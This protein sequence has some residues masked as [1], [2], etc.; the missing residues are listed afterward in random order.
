MVFIA[1]KCQSGEASKC[2]VDWVPNK[3]KIRIQNEEDNIRLY[4]K[5]A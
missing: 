2:T 4:G 3:Y 1:K 5:N